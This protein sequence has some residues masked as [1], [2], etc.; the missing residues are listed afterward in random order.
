[1]KYFE[2]F[3]KGQTMVFADGYQVTEEEIVEIASRFDPQ[4]FHVDKEAAKE[5]M[6]GGLVACSAHIFSMWCA[7]GAFDKEHEPTAAVSALGF[8][9]MRTRAPVRPGDTLRVRAT[10]TGTRHSK[11][12][13]DC[14]ILELDSEMYNQDDTVVFSID[15]AFLVKRRSAE[16]A[17]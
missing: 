3:A 10:I 6:F 4:P 8:N 17:A 14:G 13:P 2:D 9:N 5:S 1:M 11:S 16:N 12:H 7:V 15:E